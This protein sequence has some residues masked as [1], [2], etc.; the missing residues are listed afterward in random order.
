MR[1]GYLATE[2]S[3]ETSHGVRAHFTPVELL[4]RNAPDIAGP[5]HLQQTLN[6]PLNNAVQGRGRRLIQSEFR[7]MA[8]VSFPALVSPAN[9]E[10]KESSAS[11]ERDSNPWPL[12]YLTQLGATQFLEAH[13]FLW[14]DSMN[15][16]K[17][18]STKERNYPRTC[19][20]QAISPY[21]H[22]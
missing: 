11:I 3:R 14:K 22:L 1:G 15:E 7:P 19:L 18:L 8:K 21:R 16:I 10:W 17:V 12:W 9:T 20:E 6:K 4:Q 5:S 2:S 13:V